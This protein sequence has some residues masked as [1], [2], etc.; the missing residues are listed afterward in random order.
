MDAE[1]LEHIFEPFFTTKVVGKGTGLGLASVHGSVLQSS[2]SIYV[3]SRPGQGT[4]FS[5]YLPRVTGGPSVPASDNIAAQSALPRWHEVLL[6]VEDEPRVRQLACEVLASAGYIVLEA[7][8]G[9]AA[10]A[11]SRAHTRPIDLLVTDI[12]MPH[13]GGPELAQILQA[14]RRGLCVLF[15]SGYNNDDALARSGIDLAA[16]ALLVKPYSPVT[17]AHRVRAL[18]DLRKPPQGLPAS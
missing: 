6:L 3:D 9:I 5:I 1:T 10:P 14:E 4:T 2:G 15:V 13:M 12:V 17:L 7:Q 18:L 8:D 11:L 16:V